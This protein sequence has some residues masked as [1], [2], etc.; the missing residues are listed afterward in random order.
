MNRITAYFILGSLI[1]NIG[2]VSVSDGA[3]PAPES[4]FLICA[5]GKSAGNVIAIPANPGMSVR[6]AADE[7][8]RCIGRMTGVELP[9]VEGYGKCGG[10]GIRLVRTEDGGRTAVDAVYFDRMEIKGE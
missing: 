1:L 8:R 2:G 3:E 9:V 6:Y 7:L 5:R 10:R 4:R